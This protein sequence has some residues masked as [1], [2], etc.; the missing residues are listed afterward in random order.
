MAK[1]DLSVTCF[2]GPKCLT[3]FPAANIV[4]LLFNQKK[5]KPIPTVVQDFAKHQFTQPEKVVLKW[6]LE[7]S[8][9]GVKH[10]IIIG[11][12]NSDAEWDLLQYG[13]SNHHVFWF[14]APSVGN[15]AFH[16]SDP[17]AKLEDVVRFTVNRLSGDGKFRAEL[18]TE[19][20]NPEHPASQALKAITTSR[21]PGGLT[22][23]ALA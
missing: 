14:G 19:L 13:F 16:V 1:I 11:F 15:R 2:A 12:P 9:S 7:Q 22:K 8:T 5:P 4:K 17:T 23:L 20:K 18:L 6:C 3:A 10:A 21:Q